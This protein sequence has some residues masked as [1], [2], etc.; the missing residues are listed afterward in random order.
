MTYDLNKLSERAYRK[1][2]SQGYSAP[3]DG[4]LITE[5]NAIDAERRAARAERRALINTTLMESAA[6]C[7][8]LEAF[9]SFAKG[10]YSHRFCNAAEGIALA[11]ENSNRVNAAL[12]NMLSDVVSDMHGVK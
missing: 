9:D 2:I 11:L 1:L 10:D 7:G 3:T 6:V 8:A 5:M 4:R 12:L